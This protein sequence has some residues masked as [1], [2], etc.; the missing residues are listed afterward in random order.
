MR[1]RIFTAICL[2][3]TVLLLHAQSVG[4]RVARQVVE[5]PLQTTQTL[6][7][8]GWKIA[9]IK[10]RDR[11]EH[12][13]WGAHATQLT[14]DAQPT[15]II[16]PGREETLVQYALIRLHNKRDRRIL[17]R[18]NPKDND[19]ARL[20][21]EHFHIEL[22]KDESFAC[23][24]LKPLAPGDYLLLNI[25]QQPQGETGEYQGYTFRVNEK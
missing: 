20:T 6:L 12:Y 18:P 4:L 19:Y 16:A 21:P 7:H 17:M 2:G 3:M 1:M 9:G 23:Q 22:T 14:D 10:L 5:L 25:E 13:L 24:P 8:P 11:Q 15:L